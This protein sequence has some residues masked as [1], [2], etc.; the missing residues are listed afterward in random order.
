MPVLPALCCQ[1]VLPVY[2]LF[3]HVEMVRACSLVCSFM[4]DF[5]CHRGSL[6]IEK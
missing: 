1:P 6:Q 5:N 3:C 4:H 2:I